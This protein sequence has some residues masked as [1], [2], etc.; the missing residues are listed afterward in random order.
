MELRTLVWGFGVQ[1]SAVWFTPYFTAASGCD[2]ALGRFVLCLGASFRRSLGAFQ[3]TGKTRVRLRAQSQRER[4]PA[5]VI[6]LG[7]DIFSKLI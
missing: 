2:V 4:T 3:G 6:L 5:S 1:A 7:F